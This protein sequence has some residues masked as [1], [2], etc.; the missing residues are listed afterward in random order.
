MRSF[1]VMLLFSDCAISLKVE[2][3][4]PISSRD[5]TGIAWSRSPRMMSWERAVRSLMGREMRW[6]TK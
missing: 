4:C 3:S 2:A 5:S 1:A 6:E